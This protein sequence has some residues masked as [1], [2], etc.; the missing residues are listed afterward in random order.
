MRDAAW[1]SSARDRAEL[2]AAYRLMRS[3]E[4]SNVMLQEYIPGT[5]ESIWM[6]NG[7]FDE[8]SDCLLVFTGQKI[9]QSPPH[10]GATTLG[11]CR[12]NPT[13]EEQ[14]KRFMKAVGYRGILDIGYRFD[15]RDGQYKLLDVNPRIGATF[16]LFVGAE[17]MDVL[18]AM[19]L[20]LT[21]QP[22]PPS[23]PQEER[24]WLVETLDVRSAVTYIRRGDI[25]L[26][27]W[28]RSLRHIDE[29]AWWARDDPLPFLAETT[30]LLVSQ[31]RKRIGRVV[32]RSRP[33]AHSG[34]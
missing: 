14:T 24:R 17:G 19:Y 33:G 6:L 28:L 11:V 25:T 5:A 26:S 1:R 10:T 23:T 29:T 21:G 32:A 34:G 20:D 9:R 13:V 30:S 16:R 4:V 2:L 22:V 7:Y 18:R 15:A 3:T 27:S 12:S 8:R 31:L